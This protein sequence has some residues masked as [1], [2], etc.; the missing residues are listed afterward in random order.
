ML[1]FLLTNHVFMT[2]Q[3]PSFPQT[4]YN[5]GVCSTQHAQ[6]I[7]KLEIL[8]SKH[9]GLIYDVTIRRISASDNFVDIRQEFIFLCTGTQHR[10]LNKHHLLLAGNIDEPSQS[11]QDGP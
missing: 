8:I 6:V 5:E 10:N 4:C 1:C 11:I 9:H 7:Q 2:C 3:V